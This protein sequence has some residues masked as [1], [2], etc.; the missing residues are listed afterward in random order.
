[1]RKS[2]DH[3]FQVKC[4][5]CGKLGPWRNTIHGAKKAWNQAS[6]ANG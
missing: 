2:G 5:V 3:V 1:V 6:V 4:S